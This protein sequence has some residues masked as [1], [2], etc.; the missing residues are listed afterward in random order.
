MTA[1]AGAYSGG[2]YFAR[3]ALTGLVLWLAA[4]ND[5]FNL[6]GAILG[7]LTFH[8][9]AHMLRYFIERDNAKPE[10]GPDA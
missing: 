5:L 8:I 6:W 2:Q 10:R 1:S 3:F 7:L 9:A 4:T